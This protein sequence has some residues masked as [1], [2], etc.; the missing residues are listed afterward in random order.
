TR[1]RSDAPPTDVHPE[2]GHNRAPT[3]WHSHHGQPSTTRAGE[4]RPG[5][6]MGGQIRTELLWIPAWTLHPGGSRRDFSEYQTHSEVCVRYQH[7][8]MFRS[9]RPFVSPR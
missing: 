2:T 7:R 3:A 4:T 6:G 1:R 9:D 5:T 8:K